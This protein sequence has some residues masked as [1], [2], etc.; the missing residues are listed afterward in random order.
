VYYGMMVDG[1]TNVYYWYMRAIRYAIVLRP[2]AFV[3]TVTDYNWDWLK[4]VTIYDF[5]TCSVC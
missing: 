2:V 4:K 5:F 3:E 1:F